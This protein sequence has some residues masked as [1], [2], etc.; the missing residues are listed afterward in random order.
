MIHAVSYQFSRGSLQSI[1]SVLEIGGV[2][3]LAQAAV[4]GLIAGAAVKLWRE[5]QLVHDPSRVAA[6]CAA[7]LIG[8]QLSADYWAF[9]YLV[10]FV[11]LLCVALFTPELMPASALARMAPAAASPERELLAA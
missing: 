5:P 1:W 8:L 11:P 4:L 3:P 7:I 10:W 9:L 6:I 2:Q